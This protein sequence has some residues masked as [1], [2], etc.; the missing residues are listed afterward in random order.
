MA[1]CWVHCHAGCTQ[2]DVIAALE[3][4]GLWQNGQRLE[5]PVSGSAK[6][7]KRPIIPVPADT[8]PVTFKHPQ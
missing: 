6:A 8:P 3:K 4:L 5:Q 7:E 2:S 1:G